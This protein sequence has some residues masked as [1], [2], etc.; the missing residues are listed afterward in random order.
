MKYLSEI[1]SWMAA[2]KASCE[3]VLFPFTEVISEPQSQPKD[4]KT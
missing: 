1:M 3:G 2:T 4:S